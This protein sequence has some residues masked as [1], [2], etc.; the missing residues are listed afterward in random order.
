MHT[1]LSGEKYQLVYVNNSLILFLIRKISLSLNITG[2]MF[3]VVKCYV[4]RVPVKETLEDCVILIISLATILAWLS[5][6]GEVFGESIEKMSYY[7]TFVS[8]LYNYS[9][10]SW[11]IPVRLSVNKDT[12]DVL[13]VIFGT[14]I[15]SI[16]L[17]WL[18][19]FYV[20]ITRMLVNL[21]STN[22]WVFLWILVYKKVDRYIDL[23]NPF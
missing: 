4:L 8:N 6:L 23:L 10:K 14:C 19:C 5:S 21:E 16:F 15:T 9:L 18:T 13:F 3:N 2:S 12:V 1:R 17:F 20:E 11:R 7:L 22:L